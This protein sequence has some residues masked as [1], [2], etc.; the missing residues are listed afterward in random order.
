MRR[1]QARLCISCVLLL[2]QSQ[3]QP[4]EPAGVVSLCGIWILEFSVGMGQVDQ[5]CDIAPVNP[6]T[7]KYGSR[8]LISAE[9]SSIGKAAGQTVCYCRYCEL[10]A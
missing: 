10:C 1:V 3:G 2:P 9:A 5:L 7:S 8:A 6:C 4:A